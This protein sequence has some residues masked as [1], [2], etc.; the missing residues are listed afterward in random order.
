MFKQKWHWVLIILVGFGVGGSFLFLK[1][2]VPKGPVRI[3]KAV[4][5]DPQPSP[6][7]E[8]IAHETDISTPHNHDHSH[9]HSHEAV[10]HTHAAETNTSSS[11]YDWRDDGVFDGS[12]PQVDPWEQTYPEQESAN[13]DDTYPPRDWYKTK[14]PE[15]RA[16]YLYAQ[17]IKQF[18]DTPEVQAIGDY[19]LKVA[20]GIP[21]TLEEYTGYLEAHYTLFPKENKMLRKFF[22]GFS[23]LTFVFTVTGPLLFLTN[24]VVADANYQY[25]QPSISYL[26]RS[27]LCPQCL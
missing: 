22:T 5:P 15:L 19:E 4:T 11:G 26:R 18:G 1:P 9:G 16:E 3:Y 24:Q 17:L 23:L 2:K 13:T 21:P 27:H 12:L 7:P 8:V 25:S 10:P 14:D 20:R 6:T